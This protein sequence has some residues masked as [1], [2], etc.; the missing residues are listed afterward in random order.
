MILTGGK[1]RRMGSD[2]STLPFG[3]YSV[4]EYMIDKYGQ[5]FDHI[6]I[7]VSKYDQLA[8]IGIGGNDTY[9]NKYNDCSV[10]KKYSAKLQVTEDIYSDCGPMSGLY[11][12]LNAADDNGVC[13][14]AVDTPFVTAGRLLSLIPEKTEGAYCV[15][16][17]NNRIQPL[18]GWY[19]KQCLPVLKS[20]LDAGNLSMLSIYEKIQ[21]DIINIEDIGVHEFFNMNDRESY[22]KALDLVRA[23]ENKIPMVSFAAWSGTGK[24]TYIEKLIPKLV[25]KDI[26]VAVVK[27]DGHDFDIDVE[28]KDTYRFKKA[29][30]VEVVISSK[31]KTA[32]IRSE[33]G[34]RSLESL[35]LSIKN[36]DLIIVEGYKFGT[37]PKIE[38]HRSPVSEKLMEHLTNRIAVISDMH[39]DIEVP[40]FDINDVD[41]VVAFLCCKIMDI[42]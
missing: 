31:S 28:G 4:I 2:K 39:W 15:A 17:T 41:S 7:S 25:E 23:W 3:R 8:H 13:V 42:Q 29:G 27:H 16:M 22:Y 9:Y 37:Q 1:S 19:S 33:S 26:K 30:A 35:A 20:L 40:C 14:V 11:S 18:C 36:V 21:G 34:D 6:Y 5:Y 10:I 38:I 12:V 32:R 24:T